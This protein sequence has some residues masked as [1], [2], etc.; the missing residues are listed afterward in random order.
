MAKEFEFSGELRARFQK[1]FKK[2]AS[3]SALDQLEQAAADFQGGRYT[4]ALKKLEALLK[5]APEIPELI[6]LYGLCH[7]ELGD[8]EKAIQLLELFAKRTK[9]VEQHPVL[10][11]CYR[12][13]KNYGK[14]KKL[15]KEL[16]AANPPEELLAE[17]R[18]VFAGSLADQ[19]EFTRAIE[20]LK[21]ATGE[22]DNLPQ[23]PTQSEL[24]QIYA[25]A[26]IYDQ[27]DN[28]PKARALFSWVAEKDTDEA[29]DASKRIAVIS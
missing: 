12:A 26:D 3:D 14:T 11:D 6:E 4:L 29:T 9:S 13:H 16:L 5:E 23:S 18:M 17:G 8:Y 24:R 28:I 21:L 7:Y 19:G 25:L 15:W 1:A 27:A 22:E 2:G 20:L 10:E